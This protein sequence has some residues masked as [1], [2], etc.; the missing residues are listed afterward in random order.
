MEKL[1]GYTSDE[2]GV[3][4]PILDEVSVDEADAR[5][6][7]VTCSA[8]VNFLVAKAEAAGLVKT[9]K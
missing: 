7:I 3:R 8:F 5:F 1:Y 6:M 9:A 4:H 2:D